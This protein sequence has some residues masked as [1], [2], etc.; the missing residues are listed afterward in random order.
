ME[1]SGLIVRR[2]ELD[3]SFGN[4]GAGRDDSRSGVLCRYI[5]CIVNVILHIYVPSKI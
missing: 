4:V 1:D 2:R 5:V 3:G